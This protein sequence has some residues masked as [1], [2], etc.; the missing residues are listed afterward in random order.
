MSKR[1]VKD[2]IDDG[3]I[4]KYRKRIIREK[5]L[6]EIRELILEHPSASRRRLSALLCELWNWRQ[7]NGILKD[8]VCRSLMLIL[9]RAGHIQLPEVRQISRNPIVERH[10]PKELDDTFDRSIITFSTKEISDSIEMKQVRKTDL[11]PV[12]NRLIQTHHYLGYTNPIGEHL[13]YLFLLNDRPIA[14][15]L[16]TSSALKIKP[17]D[18]YLG[19]CPVARD[20]NVRMIAYNSRF[21]VLPWVRVKYLASHLLG[22]M[23]RQISDDWASLYCHPIHLLETY[24]E[25]ERFKGS[26]YRAANWKMVGLTKGQGIRGKSNVK[27]RSEKEMFVYPCS[28][29]HIMQLCHLPE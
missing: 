18:E 21:L 25:P 17:R 29:N 16:W 14:C 4:L 11:E 20:V 26:C 10:K 6:I 2:E 3:I 12:F 9:H 24:I 15:A 27:D 5:N 1:N 7:E 23:S 19:W 13:K 8:M 22:R 28:K